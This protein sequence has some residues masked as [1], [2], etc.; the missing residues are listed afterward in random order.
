MATKIANVALP[1]TITSTSSTT[2]SVND[3]EQT[4]IAV[5]YAGPNGNNPSQ[6]SNYLFVWQ[7]GPSM[8]IGQPAIQS[9]AA[10]QGGTSIPG[11]Y[12]AETYVVGYSVGPS[13]TTGGTTTYPNVSAT[14]A[15][16]ADW[17]INKATYFTSN[18]GITTVQTNFISFT[19][20]LPTNVNPSQNGAW[21][22]LWNGAVAPYEVPPIQA[23]PVTATSS[24]GSVAMTGLG[25]QP[26]GTYTAALFTSG[27]STDP[28][29]LDLTTIAVVIVFDTSSSLN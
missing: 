28:T 22:G 26:R 8:P 27:Y 10:V 4:F 13:V 2:L 19:Y 6:Y 14:A 17:D 23:A 29:K 9:A 24:S 21:V 3:I 7:G 11:Q 18:L 25:V 1:F 5:S 16:P 12:D 20:V 15:I